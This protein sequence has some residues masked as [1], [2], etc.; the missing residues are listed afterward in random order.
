MKFYNK[1]RLF[2]GSLLRRWGR[3]KR[4]ISV[5]ITILESKIKNRRIYCRL[6]LKIGIKIGGREKIFPTG[7][8]VLPLGVTLK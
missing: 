2:L 1:I 8:V 4:N 7:I 6:R 3:T 5:K